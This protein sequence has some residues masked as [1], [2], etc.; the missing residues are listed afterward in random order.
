MDSA[1]GNTVIAI[2]TQDCLNPFKTMQDLS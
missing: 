2:A 1:W